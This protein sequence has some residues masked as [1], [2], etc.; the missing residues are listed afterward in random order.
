M[1]H[2][3]VSLSIVMMNGGATQN[4]MRRDRSSDDLLSPV[5]M[6]GWEV[7]LFDGGNYT[8]SIFDTMHTIMDNRKSL[9][10]SCKMLA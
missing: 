10:A 7:C 8:L 4:A 5:L 2:P 6:T 9:F 3:L 1:I